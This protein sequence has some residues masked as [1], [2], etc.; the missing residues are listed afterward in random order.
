MSRRCATWASPAMLR[1]GR[2]AGPALQVCA[3]SRLRPLVVGYLRIL[4][5]DPPGHGDQL[6]AELSTFADRSGLALAD[7]YTEHPDVSSRQGAAFDALIEALRRP[8]IHAVLIPSPQHFSR[9][10]G[11][12]RAMCTVIDIETGADILIMRSRSGGDAQ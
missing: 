10:G 11:M 4:L 12:Y 2:V 8:H 6:A 1:P 3:G 5:T 9:F 7:I